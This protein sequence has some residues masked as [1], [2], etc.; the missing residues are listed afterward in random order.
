MNEVRFET[1]LGPVPA[2]ARVE[3]DDRPLLLVVRGAFPMQGQLNSL[4]AKIPWASVV[5]LNLPGMHSPQ[6]Q[7]NSISAFADAF[8]EVVD[9]LGKRTVVLG[10]SIGGA[11]AMAL[12]SP[13]VSRRIVVDTPLRTEGLW[14]LFPRFREIADHNPKAREWLATP[15]IKIF[16]EYS[17]KGAV[18]ARDSIT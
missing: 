14:P 17:E 5:L 8:D 18:S 9:Q 4:T 13:H 16:P 2:V 3:L 7:E 11:A 6:F 15:D 1:S 10:L 12:R